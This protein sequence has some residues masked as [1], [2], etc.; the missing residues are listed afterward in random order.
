MQLAHPL[1][2]LLTAVPNIEDL[3][4][5]ES[6]SG[7]GILQLSSNP[8]IQTTGDLAPIAKPIAPRMTLLKPTLLDRLDMYVP[9]KLSLML[10]LIVF[11]GNWILHGLVMFLYY[12]F[13]IFQRLV[14]RFFKHQDD[15]IPLKQ[16]V[17]VPGEFSK[18]LEQHLHPDLQKKYH[19]LIERVLASSISQPT[20]PNLSRA[21]RQ[22]TLQADASSTNGIP[23]LQEKTKRQQSLS[24]Q[25]MFLVQTP[26]TTQESPI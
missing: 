16:V 10:T 11:I 15:K 8:T 12:R 14:P 6:E 4:Y 5:F 1:K 9:V 18:H 22:G 3:P 24:G 2:S 21:T 13:T 23:S 19:F 20:T 26:P 25:N 7:A 17:S